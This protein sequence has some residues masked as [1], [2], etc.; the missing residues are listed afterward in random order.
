MVK[1]AKDGFESQSEYSNYNKWKKNRCAQSSTANYWFTVIDLEILLF[2]FIRSLRE[3]NFS[4]FVMSLKNIAPWMFALDHIHYAR[5]LPVFLE[6]LEQMKNAN[7][8]VVDQFNKGFFTVN[9]TGHPFS[10]IGIDQAHEQNN[11][12]VKVDGGAIGILDNDAALLKWAIAGPIISEI[13]NEADGSLSP[14]VNQSKHHEDTDLFEK[15]FQKD[16]NAFLTLFTEY[17]NPFCENEKMLVQI[18]S[19]HVLDENATTSVQKAKEIGMNQ[20]DTFVNN[21]LR[22]GSASLYD[23]ITKNNLPLYHSKNTILT[24]RSKKRI[25]NLEADSRLYAN[26]FAAC[27]ARDGDLKNFF[28]HEN[29]AYPVFLSIWEIE[30]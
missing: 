16:R 15:N 3:G 14:S 9:K 30:V 2:I 28:T 19:K 1:L 25:T 13:L 5:W 20:F 21:R 8:P 11:K 17:G 12:I 6:D 27:Q 4:L 26:L 29:H 18:V 7:N 22:N 10:N 24:S 23:N